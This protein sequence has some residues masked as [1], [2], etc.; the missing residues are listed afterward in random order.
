[1][2]FAPV[3]RGLLGRTY[4]MPLVIGVVSTAGLL[5][6]LIGD[7]PWDTLSWLALGFPVAIGLW[8]WFRRT[9]SRTQRT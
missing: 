5:F 2:T 9:G 1:M 4:L 8:F 3:W 6:A 7:G